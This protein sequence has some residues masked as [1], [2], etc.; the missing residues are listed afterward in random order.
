[1]FN[2]QELFYN[3]AY[4][5]IIFTLLYHKTSSRDSAITLLSCCLR[6]FRFKD[7]SWSVIMSPPGKWD[8]VGRGGWREQQMWLS[9]C[10][11]GKHSPKPLCP[12]AS[13][14]STNRGMIHLES[15]ASSCPRLTSTAKINPGGEK[16]PFNFWVLEK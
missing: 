2:K 4:L 11:L 8:L 1:M 6:H 9:Q 3:L 5:L 7:I 16:S 10:Y 12:D 15:P 14:L 13:S